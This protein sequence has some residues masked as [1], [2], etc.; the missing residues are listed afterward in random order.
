MS[1]ISNR[2]AFSPEPPAKTETKNGS[3]GRFK[4]SLD[5]ATDLAH[6]A[7]GYLAATRN[8]F[9]SEAMRNRPLTT[10]GLAFGLGVF[11]GWLVKRR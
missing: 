2:F 4:F 3:G 8:W 5:T 6:N 7:G 1:S 10:L 11:A 9:E